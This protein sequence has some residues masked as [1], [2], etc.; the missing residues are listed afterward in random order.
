MRHEIV[1]RNPDVEVRFY[2]SVDEGSYVTPHWHDSIEMVYMIEGSMTMICEQERQE[3][4]PGE[5]I[6]V[7][8]RL[9]HSILST[10]NK[11]IVLQIPK[12]V[13]KK[14]VPDIDSY[15]FK[16]DL[17][18]E[19]RVEQT[20][21]ERVRKIFTDMQVIYDVRPEGYLLKFNSLLYDLLFLLIH[22]YS[23]KIVQ[24]NYDKEYKYLERLNEIM[25]Y[26]K[27][28][29]RERVMIPALA[30][31][32]GYNEDYLARFFK[33][34]TGMTV[35]EYLYAYRVTKVY[36]D[37]MNTDKS[38]NEILEEHGCANYR[39][40]MR[41]FK[42]LYGCTPKQKRKQSKRTVPK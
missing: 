23:H 19:S 40:A 33:K 18:P 35:N 27:D 34:Q 12:E 24:K 38:V 8:S 7:N 21:L 20:R 10:K 15:M 9:V 25:T 4:C 28:H 11:A 13:I 41:V 5:F 36:Q 6:V 30:Q 42:E 1:S 3:L 26:L 17:H 16:V 39:V 22:S 2:L 31:K 14:Y 32:F 29:H 37:L